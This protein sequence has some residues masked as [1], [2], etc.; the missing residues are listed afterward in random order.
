MYITNIVK[1]RPP[2][3]RDPF[4]DEIEAYAP[5]LDRQIEIIEPRIIAT[6]GRYAMQYILEKFNLWEELQPIGKLHGRVFE[7]D[8]PYGKLKII[9]ALSS[10]GGDIQQGDTR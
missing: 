2:R 10:R 4:P 1:D 3:N 8:A 7:A 6:L 5:F 9:P